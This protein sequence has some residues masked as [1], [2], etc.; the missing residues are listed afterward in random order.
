MDS[1][2]NIKEFYKI[3]R[4][5]GKGNF[6]SVRKAK[7]RATNEYVAVKVLSKKK[8]NEDDRLQLMGEIEIMK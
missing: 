6:A 4:T 8:M 5:I 3:E 7:N 2:R 1:N